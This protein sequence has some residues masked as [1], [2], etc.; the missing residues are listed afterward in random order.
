[1]KVTRIETAEVVELLAATP[2]RVATLSVG[3]DEA[4]LHQR[5]DAKSW[6]ANDIMAHLRACADVW[7]TTIQAMLAGDTPTLE[8]IS[9]RAW[10]KK[11]DYRAVGF[12]ESLT[13]FGEQRR[14][15]LA[16]LSD[17]AFDDWSRAAI[18][19]ERRH[20]VFSQSRRMAYHE[21]IHCQQLTE[22]SRIN[23]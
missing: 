19:K 23:R 3:L 20:T 13:A 15:L 7:G 6:S 1:M 18:I 17:L 14:R 8:Y 2:R 21:V 5:P 12:R 10:M 22:V 11:T 16:T 9:P 4:Q